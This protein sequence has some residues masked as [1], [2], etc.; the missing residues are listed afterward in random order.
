MEGQPVDLTKP[1]VEG[2]QFMIT[3]LPSGTSA[4]DIKAI[5]AQYVASTETL[6]VDVPTLRGESKGFAIVHLAEDAE[7]SATCEAL[8]ETIEVAVG[9][10]AQSCPIR[11]WD[12][13]FSKII[14]LSLAWE[15]SSMTVEREMS[16]YGPVVECFI[17]I[18]R[19]TQ[20]SR[21]F[22]FVVF[23]DVVSAEEVLSRTDHVIDGRRVEM[24]QAV[25]QDGP[26]KGKGGKGEGFVTN[27]IFVAKISPATSQESLQE[28]FSKYGEVVDCY[29]PR[30]FATGKSKGIGFVSFSNN[31]AVEKLVADSP[32]TIGGVEVAVD[33][34]EPKESKGKGKKGYGRV[35]GFKGGWDSG[36]WGKGYGGRGGGYKG[37]RGYGGYN[38]YDSGYGNDWGKGGGG[39]WNDGWNGGGY[40]G[41]GGYGKGKGDFGKGK[42]KV[43]HKPA[44]QASTYVPPVSFAKGGKGSHIAVTNRIFVGRL[45]F[46]TT[47][48]SLT[49][50]F[51]QYGPVK[52]AYIPKDY[53]TGESRG[54]AFVTFE[55]SEPVEVIAKQGTP[56]VVDG[57]E[58]AIDKAEMK[59]YPGSKGNG[60]GGYGQQQ[61]QPQQQMQQGYPQQM[62]QPVGGA[63]YGQ[64][65]Q[66][67][68]WDGNMS[69]LGMGGMDQSVLQQQQQQLQATADYSAQML[70][71]TDAYAQQQ[72]TTAAAYQA[73][74]HTPQGSAQYY[75]PY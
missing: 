67:G 2:N 29:M 55:S 45:N 74:R 28:H 38:E 39:G 8:G 15:T 61:Q 70:Q 56:V 37:G 72:Q 48:E 11:I 57:R 43:P 49:S 59:D 25:K 21:G 50:F 3:K 22:C 34:A 68:Q 32:H 30:D 26:G 62:Q 10:V 60:G 33:K 54:F 1:W 12:P 7:F 24:K 13:Q 23:A 75:R 40:G 36:G 52:D 66:G 18:D 41:G 42:G 31:D 17:P 65:D 51:S 5:F 44:F 69:Q 53:N 9:G 47:R 46:T 4:A 73:I 16:E 71:S 14:I 27:R 64:P 19:V 35:G 58:V 63:A 20:R 6:T